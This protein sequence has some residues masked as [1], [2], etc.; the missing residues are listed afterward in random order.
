MGGSG[1]FNE[2]GFFAI[3]ETVSAIKKTGAL[4]AGSLKSKFANDEERE[5]AGC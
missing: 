3:D 5:C 4:R 2:L 1:H